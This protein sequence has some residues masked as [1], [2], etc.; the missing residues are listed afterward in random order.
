MKAL[1]V[2]EKSAQPYRQEMRF[3]R[4][5]LVA[6]EPPVRGGGDAGPAPFGYLLCALGACTSIT[7]KMYAQRK[8]WDLGTVKV[9]C[10]LHLRAGVPAEIRRAVMIS[11]PLAEEQRA[12]LAEIAERTPVTLVVNKGL[13]VRT[14]FA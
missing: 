14:T 7:L 13:A 9:E 3:E 8:G 11:A 1:V 10:E 4:H 2:G 6:D 5:E 12:R